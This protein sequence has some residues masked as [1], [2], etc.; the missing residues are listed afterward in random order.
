MEVLISNQDNRYGITVD[1]KKA[2]PCVHEDLLEAT[3][4][5]YYFE[6]LNALG[7]PFLDHQ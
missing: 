4:E 3:Q 6:K 1:G 5:W 7:T 2:V